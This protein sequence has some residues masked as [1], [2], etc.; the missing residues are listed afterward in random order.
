[1]ALKSLI[2]AMTAQRVSLLISCPKATLDRLTDVDLDHIVDRSPCRL[3]DG[4]EILDDLVLRGESVSQ[5]LH[6]DIA[7]QS[8]T[9]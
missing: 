4:G 2:S 7:T 9:V 6:L 1:M 8:F 5:A 3:E